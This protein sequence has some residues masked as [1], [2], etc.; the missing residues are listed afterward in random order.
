M[1]TKDER[2]H[3]RTEERR[4][5]NLGLLGEEFSQSAPAI[6]RGQMGLQNAVATRNSKQVE[7]KDKLGARGARHGNCRTKFSNL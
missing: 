7:E 5:T 6:L 1:M 2:V 4:K 3:D